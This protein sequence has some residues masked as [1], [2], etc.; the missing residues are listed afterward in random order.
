MKIVI[1]NII[2]IVSPLIIR[3]NYHENKTTI[4]DRNK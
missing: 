1:K 2:I 3:I 4:Y